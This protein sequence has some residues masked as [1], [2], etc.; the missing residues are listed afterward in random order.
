MIRGR[1][2]SKCLTRTERVQCDGEYEVEK[3]VQKGGTNDSVC[4]Y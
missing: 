3:K 1:V 4:I 2:V